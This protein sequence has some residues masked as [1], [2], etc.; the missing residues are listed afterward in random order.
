M[1]NDLRRT[2]LWRGVYREVDVEV[3][4]WECGGEERWNYYIRLAVDRLPAETRPRFVLSPS[5]FRDRRGHAGLP[6]YPREAIP[7]IDW[8]GGCTYY[9]KQGGR[10]GGPLFVKMGCDYAHLYDQGCRYTLD[11][12]AADARRSIDALWEQFPDM[13]HACSYNGGL[14]RADEGSVQPSGA[15]LSN[16]GAAQDAA[17][18][19]RRA[20]EK[21]ST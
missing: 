17:W 20:K 15:W 3:A 18:R 10:D 5:C 21:G 19:E 4:R 6:G 12:V 7:D 11:M 13:L 14:Y 2:E 8:H 9:E 1:G 16:E